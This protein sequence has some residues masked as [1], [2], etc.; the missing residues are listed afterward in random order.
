MKINHFFSFQALIFLSL[1]ILLFFPVNCVSASNKWG[2]SLSSQLKGRAVWMYH[3]SDLDNEETVKD[4]RDMGINIVFLSTDSSKLLPSGENSS[5]I[6][7]QK[8]H[9]F[10]GKAHNAGIKIHAMTLEDT[11]FTFS[12][13][14]KRGEELIKWI[15][16]FSVYSKPNEAFDGIHIDTEP[17]S[18]AG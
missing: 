9:D 14:H 5:I 12:K 17:H 4:L 3:F 2:A 10:I 7:T 6:Y 8:I 1:Q 11:G 16:D 13:Y 18:L 15:V